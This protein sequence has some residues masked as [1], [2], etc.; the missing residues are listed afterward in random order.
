MDPKYRIRSIG[1]PPGLDITF[2]I[3][4]TEL[5]GIMRDAIWHS[6]VASSK[7]EGIDISDMPKPSVNTIP[8]SMLVI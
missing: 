7:I 4:K 6:V 1:Q 5:K 8:D 3:S 2:S